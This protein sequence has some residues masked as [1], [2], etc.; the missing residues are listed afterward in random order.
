MSM[1]KTLEKL[2]VLVLGGYLSVASCDVRGNASYYGKDFKAN[3]GYN[4]KDNYG[5][6]VQFNTKI[7]YD[8]KKV[9]TYISPRL[10]MLIDKIQVLE[11]SESGSYIDFNGDIRGPNHEKIS[12][13]YQDDD[14]RGRLSRQICKGK[15]KLKVYD[16]LDYIGSK[17]LN[18]SF[19]YLKT[20]EKKK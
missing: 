7:F 13:G 9:N 16:V 3:I 1:S 2:A 15:R 14:E 4:G 20:F 6:N 12:F 19:E 17:K 5:L 11:N 18:V 10:N 8:K